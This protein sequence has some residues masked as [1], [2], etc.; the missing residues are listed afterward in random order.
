[1]EIHIEELEQ[2]RKLDYYCIVILDTHVPVIRIPSLY[3]SLK[4]LD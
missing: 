2:K 4:K 1:M 3:L